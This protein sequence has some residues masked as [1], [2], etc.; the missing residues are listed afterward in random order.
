MILEIY[1]SEDIF[2]AVEIVSKINF[3]KPPFWISRTESVK[4]P[5][6]KK[7]DVDIFW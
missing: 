5:C 6:A 4:T 3:S 7:G 2:K 1:A